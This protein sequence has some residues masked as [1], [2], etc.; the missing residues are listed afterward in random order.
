MITKLWKIYKKSH[1]VTRLRARLGVKRLKIII[2]WE[3]LL[4][5]IRRIFQEFQRGSLMYFSTYFCQEFL[6]WF[7]PKYFMKIVNRFY[8]LRKKN[9]SEIFCNYFSSR[10][11]PP[12]FQE[13]HLQKFCKDS[14][15]KSFK[16]FTKYSS[17]Q[18][19]RKI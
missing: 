7:L 11:I 12:C 1:R 3:T 5:I 9:A 17:I 14:F 10:V 4:R 16:L 8:K 15:N 19:I 2:T 13:F 18:G 6:Q